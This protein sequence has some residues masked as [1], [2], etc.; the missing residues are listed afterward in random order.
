MRELKNV[1][2]HY[3]PREEN[4]QADKLVNKALDNHLREAKTL[5]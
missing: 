1:S 2:F 3:I 4:K 5:F